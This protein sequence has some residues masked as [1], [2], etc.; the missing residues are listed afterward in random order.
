MVWLFSF[1]EDIAMAS[2]KQHGASLSRQRK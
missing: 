1:A 2:N